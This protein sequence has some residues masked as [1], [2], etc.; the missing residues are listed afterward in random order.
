[1]TKI[2]GS[3]SE[4]GSRSISQL[5]GSGDPDPDPHQNVMDPQHLGVLYYLY[6]LSGL[7]SPFSQKDKNRC[8][9]ENS[10]LVK[11]VQLIKRCLRD[12]YMPIK[13]NLVTAFSP[14]WRLVKIKS[15]DTMKIFQNYV[16]YM[17]TTRKSIQ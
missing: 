10:Y 2:A 4:P 15:I 11:P 12:M 14:F 17:L 8:I 1:M 5:N 3:R 9:L 7:Y 13:K 16:Y 6:P